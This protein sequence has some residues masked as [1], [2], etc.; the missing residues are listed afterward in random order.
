MIKSCQPRHLRCLFASVLAASLVASTVTLQ[1][2]TALA[3]ADITELFPAA[4]TEARL[5][6]HAPPTAT[7]TSPPPRLYH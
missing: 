7:P 2:A 5:T 4:D 3:P 6:F 1:A